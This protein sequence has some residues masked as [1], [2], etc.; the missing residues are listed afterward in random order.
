MQATGAESVN[1]APLVGA[2]LARDDGGTSRIDAGWPAAIASKLGSHKGLL[3]LAQQSLHPRIQP[4]LDF[5]F[6]MRGEVIDDILHDQL[7][8][9]A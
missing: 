7:C 2:E 8:G 1:T 5:G 4:T 9:G 6:D 3:V